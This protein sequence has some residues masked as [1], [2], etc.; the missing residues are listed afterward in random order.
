[1]QP[2]IWSKKSHLLKRAD[3]LANIYPADQHNNAK[4]DSQC[5]PPVEQHG[6]FRISKGD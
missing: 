3:A 6:F 5:H 2:N 1:M 4:S